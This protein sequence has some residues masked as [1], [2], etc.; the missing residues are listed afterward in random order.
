MKLVGEGHTWFLGGTEELKGSPGGC[1]RTS[2]LHWNP[3]LSKVF[4]GIESPWIQSVM[5]NGPRAWILLYR[6]SKSQ[7]KDPYVGSLI[8][9]TKRGEISGL[10]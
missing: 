4:L 5:L 2:L 1:S 8:V 9:G 7:T 3:P 10:R 6:V